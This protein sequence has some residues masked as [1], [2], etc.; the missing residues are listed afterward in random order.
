MSGIEIRGQ[1]PYFQVFDMPTSIRFYTEVLGFEVVGVR[2]LHL[3]DPDG[4]GICFQWPVEESAT[5][6]D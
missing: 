1:C 5:S 2:Q 3:E 6:D 4:Y